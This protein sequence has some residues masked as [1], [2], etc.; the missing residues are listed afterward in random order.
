MC[1]YFPVL[2]HLSFHPHH[3]EQAHLFYQEALL[4]SISLLPVVIFTSF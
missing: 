4:F 2:S 1:C 3:G